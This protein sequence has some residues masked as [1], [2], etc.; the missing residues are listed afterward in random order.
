[1]IGGIG[2][3]RGGIRSGRGPCYARPTP[4]PEV[5]RSGGGGGG[6]SSRT[7]LS[8]Q[9]IQTLRA[10]GARGQTTLLK[11]LRVA[12]TAVAHSLLGVVAIPA[13]VLTVPLG[14]LI[15]AT[16]GRGQ[17]LGPGMVVSL[18]QD[19][20]ESPLHLR[21]VGD[22]VRKSAQWEFASTPEAIAR[23]AR[24]GYGRTK[25]LA[26]LA[27]EFQRLSPDQR[28]AVRALFRQTADEAE[29]DADLARRALLYIDQL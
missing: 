25:F 23:V 19:L 5:R 3:R 9:E 10:L 16:A 17:G 14:W 28:T 18:G 2:S 29:P 12:G 21:T 20:I 24:H 6:G 7:S 27:V 8:A 1:M 13:S 15:K 26:R 11:G 22:R 4:S